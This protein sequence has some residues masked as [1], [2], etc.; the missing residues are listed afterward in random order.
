VPGTRNCA[1]PGAAATAS[2]SRSRVRFINRNNGRPTTIRRGS[3]ARWRHRAEAGRRSARGRSCRP[4]A[5]S[6]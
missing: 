3:A 1:A 2:T 5:P 4:P 6:C